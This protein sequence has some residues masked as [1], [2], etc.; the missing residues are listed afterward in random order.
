MITYKLTND[1]RVIK[2]NTKSGEVWLIPT[3]SNSTWMAQEY[4]EW[5][6]DGNTPE[7]A[8]EVTE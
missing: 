7:P 3:N 1:S 5:L 6:A 8:D 2:T 4:Q